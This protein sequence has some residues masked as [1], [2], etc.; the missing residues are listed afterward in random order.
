MRPK[1]PGPRVLTDAR[2]VRLANAEC[3]RTLADLRPQDSGPFGQAIA[4]AQTA[5]QIDR[6]AAGLDSLA[7][8]L[9]ALPASASDRP[10]VDTWL[11]GWHRYTELG[12]QYAVFLRQY[13][14]AQPGSLLVKSVHEASV[15]DNFA[16][17]NGL[18]S[19]TF[20][21]TPQPDPSNGF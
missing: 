20:F 11:D 17:A 5:A 10:H 14:N 12:R 4:P 6:A 16:L 3:V 8:R 19:C 13:G 1:S 7:N 15:A 9:R 21:A 18:G 2:Y